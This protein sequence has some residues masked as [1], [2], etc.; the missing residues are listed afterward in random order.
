[1]SE[2]A[3]AGKACSENQSHKGLQSLQ[4]GNK[5]FASCIIKSCME[6]RTK[7]NDILTYIH[8]RFQEVVKTDRIY[9]PKKKNSAP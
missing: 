1:M 4:R 8:G 7:P 6:A 5:C 9:F 3:E 2:V